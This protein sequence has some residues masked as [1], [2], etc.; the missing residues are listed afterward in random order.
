MIVG[1]TPAILDISIG[2][3]NYM[4]LASP[5]IIELE[6]EMDRPFQDAATSG[7]A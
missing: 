1:P 5:Y 2:D 6:K 3:V 4:N 7:S